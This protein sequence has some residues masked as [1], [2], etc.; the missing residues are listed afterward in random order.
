MKTYLRI[1]RIHPETFDYVG[2]FSPVIMP[3]NNTEAPVFQSM[4]TT[5]KTQMDNGYELYWIA[6]GRENF[7]FD[8]V[9]AYRKRLD[10]INIPMSMWRPVAAT[11]GPYG[12]ST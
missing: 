6:I 10:G 8:E 7:L 11:S 12:G 4:D 5:L 9:I 1:S 3:R 2:L